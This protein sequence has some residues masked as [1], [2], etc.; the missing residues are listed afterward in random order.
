M[1][2]SL[3]DRL[4]EVRRDGAAVA[5]LAAV[6]LG[7]CSKAEPQMAPPPP[8]A[9]SVAEVIGRDVAE[10]D[11]FSG[12]LE[13]VERVDIRPRVNGYLQAIHFKQ[14]AEVKKGE[15]L[16]TIDP[17]PYQA[18]LARA[19]A[20]LAGARTRADLARTELARSERLLADNAIA[21]RE[22]DE[23]VA[24]RGDTDASIRAAEAAVQSARLNMEFTQVR[25]PIAGRVSKEEVTVGNLVVGDG[26]S[27]TLL[28]SVVSQDP[29]YVS[30][31]GDE[32]V[33]LKYGAM[34]RTGERPSSRRAANPVYMGLANEAGFPHQGHMEFVDN[35]LDP[36]T[37]TIR[38]RA[39]FDNRN[40][41][42]TPGLFARI[43]LIGSGTYPAVLIDDK[44]VGTDQ[45]KKFVLV[46]GPENKVGYRP[47]KLGP[48]VDGLRVVKEGLKPGE[49]IVVNGLQRV[50]P[51]D[52][53]TPQTVPM[54]GPEQA[55]SRLPLPENPAGAK[56]N[57]KHPG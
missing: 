7:A 55:A 44:A 10:W 45:S 27:P 52:P 42:F 19:E 54:E 46:L 23:R 50:K 25:S 2:Q 26:P 37:G 47:V 51:G 39:V 36:Q 53:V 5:L 22:Y 11:E 13:A 12:R 30:F 21:R 31:E 17:R 8:P 35:R 16:F 43:K 24:A 41:L 28:T 57:G 29:I 49:L 9:V 4:V 15:L 34:A 38:A 56:A 40:G 18:E 3:I 1:I 6:F 33:Y 14:G 32:Q 20:A 48:M